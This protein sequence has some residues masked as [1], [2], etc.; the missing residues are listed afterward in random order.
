M[1]MNIKKETRESSH[2]TGIKNYSTKNTK[3]KRITHYKLAFSWS[4]TPKN[5]VIERSLL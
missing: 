3:R 1:K 4:Q 5:C 2:N